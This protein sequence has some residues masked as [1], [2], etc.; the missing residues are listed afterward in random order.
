M[1]AKLVSSDYWRTV[2]KYLVQTS[3]IEL[4][5]MDCI[6]LSCFHKQPVGSLRRC[7]SGLVVMVAV[8]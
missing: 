5:T 3:I 4:T 1:F 7:S 8:R 6:F 2:K